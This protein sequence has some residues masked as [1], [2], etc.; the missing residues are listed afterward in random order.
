M[1]GVLVERFFGRVPAGGIIKIVRAGGREG[2]HCS[3]VTRG[4]ARAGKCVE[5]LPL[6]LCG[7]LSGAHVTRCPFAAR[8]SVCQQS[9]S[10]RS[11]GHGGV[12]A[13]RRPRLNVPLLMPTAVRYGTIWYYMV[14]YGTIWYYRFSGRRRRV[15]VSQVYVDALLARNTRRPLFALP[16]ARRYS[17]KRALARRASLRGSGTRRREARAPAETARRREGQPLT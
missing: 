3:L 11:V 7:V 14:L 15:A 9:F 5:C 4:V 1:A 6:S 8:A 13:A 10:A 16:P 2:G 12:C 17:A